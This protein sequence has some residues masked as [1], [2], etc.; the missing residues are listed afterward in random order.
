MTALLPKW[1]NR[2]DAYLVSMKDVPFEWGNNDCLSFTNG[3]HQ[4]MTGFGYCDDLVGRAFTAMEAKRE[5]LAE[6][7]AR[8][9]YSGTEL[10]DERLTR[11]FCIPKRG[12]IVATLAEKMATGY[13]LGVVID[14]ALAAFIGYEGIETRPSGGGEFVWRV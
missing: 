6:M 9:L 2:L 14:D 11:A 12:M 5:Y 1:S 7:K 8:K 3:A 13:A 10:I 4:A